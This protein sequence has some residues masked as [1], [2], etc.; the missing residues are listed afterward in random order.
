MNLMVYLTFLGYIYYM[1]KNQFIDELSMQN[2]TVDDGLKL[3]WIHKFNLYNS[4]MG[5]LF[6]YLFFLVFIGLFI[7]LDFMGLGLL[8]YKSGKFV[9]ILGIFQTYFLLKNYFKIRE[10]FQKEIFSKEDIVV[11]KKKFLK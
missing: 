9:S 2:E 3:F 1:N 5:E 7:I 4:N 11:F 10:L 8:V 6:G